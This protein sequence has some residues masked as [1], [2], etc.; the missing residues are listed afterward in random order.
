MRQP[1]EDAPGVVVRRIVLWPALPRER[2][3]L[4]RE[5]PG[6]LEDETAS[7]GPGDGG[8]ADDADPVCGVDHDRRIGESSGVGPSRVVACP[9]DPDGAHRLAAPEHDHRPSIL[10]YTPS[11]RIGPGQEVESPP[12]GMQRLEGDPFTRVLPID[13]L[14]EPEDGGTV[15]RSCPTASSSSG[16]PGVDEPGDGDEG[17]ERGE[18]QRHR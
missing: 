16:P 2:R 6:Q 4:R 9:L 1:F 18:D 12:G 3:R 5:L 7:D 17:T 14:L 11:S 13:L 8:T 15:G 10:G